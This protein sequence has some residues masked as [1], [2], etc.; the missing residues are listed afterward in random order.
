VRNSYV[1][2]REVK[3]VNAIAGGEGPI[4]YILHVG[5]FYIPLEFQPRM[6]NCIDHHSTGFLNYTSILSNIAMLLGLF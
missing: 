3:C 2:G 5:L 1:E 6:T 4:L